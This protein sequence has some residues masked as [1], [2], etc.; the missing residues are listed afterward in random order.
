MKRR[1]FLVLIPAIPA[2]FKAAVLAVVKGQ[3][4]LGPGYEQ[5]EIWSL[6]EYYR[7]H[8]DIVVVSHDVWRLL[9]EETGG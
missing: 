9:K 6:N 4:P 1:G 7:P 8:P 5:W 2:G 3:V